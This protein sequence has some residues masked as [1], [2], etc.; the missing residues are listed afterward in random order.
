MPWQAGN[1]EHPQNGFPLRLPRLATRSIILAPH[2]GHE[3]RMTPTGEAVSRA[4]TIGLGCVGLP[5]FLAAG[6][7][8]RMRVP[9]ILRCRPYPAAPAMPRLPKKARPFCQFPTP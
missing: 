8:A 9:P 1:L 3:L 6:E 7:G 5:A 4:G 2:T